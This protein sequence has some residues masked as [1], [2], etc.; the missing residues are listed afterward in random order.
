MTVYLVISLPRIPY[1]HRIY[2]VLANPTHLRCMYGV[3]GREK[4]AHAYGRPEP[5]IYGAC[6]VF[7][8]GNKGHMPRVGRNHTNTVN[9][10]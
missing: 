10:R 6:T 1:V 9:V 2:M 3:F 8:A 5:H 4:R 7:L